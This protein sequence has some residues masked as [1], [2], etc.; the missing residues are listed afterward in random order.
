[1]SSTLE[2]ASA[3]AKETGQ[4]LKNYF[5]KA[6]LETELKA[7]HSVVTEADLAADQKIRSAIQAA[8]PG[9][10]L[11]TEES[12]TLVADLDTP[13]W[14]IDPLDGTTNFRLGLPIW[15]I[16]IARLENGLP[17]MGVLYFP[18]ADELYT[19]ERGKGAQ[20]NG[21]PLKT[22]P[23]DQHPPYTFFT[24]CS[25]TF[26]KYDV[27]LRYKARILGAAA[28]DFCVV[29]RGAAIIGFQATLKLW[30]LAAGWLILEE[31]GGVADVL[32]GPPPFPIQPKIEYNQLNYPTIL[33]A[34]LESAKKGKQNIKKK[35]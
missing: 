12:D 31:A 24:C 7:D 10:H 30:D 19:A 14:V 29:A 28:Y 1:M 22:P 3:L 35:A 8:Y 23:G 16:S 17:Q 25:R 18:V 20:L 26:R 32:S 9:E 2:F 11:L 33:A 27:S 15:G 4:I 6:S 21:R 13:V 34:D 5:H